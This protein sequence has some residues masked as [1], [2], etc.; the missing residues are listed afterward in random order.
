MRISLTDEQVDYCLELGMA[1]HDAKDKS[2]RNR[3]VGKFQN[4]SKHTLADY[5]KVDPQYM[6]HFIGV[7]GEMAWSIHTGEALDEEIYAV[8]DNGEDFEGTEVKTL[9]YFGRGEPELKIPESEYK[10]RQSVQRYVLARV[11]P[12]S[13]NDVELLGKIDREIFDVLK[14]KKQ[15]GVSKP[16]NFIVPQ[17]SME[18]V[19]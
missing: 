12:K 14:E 17:S 7:L 8:R 1:R 13:P 11:D 5:V 16:K 10:E 2:F 3:D 19:E 15:Y 4:Q 18:R 9:T 6:A